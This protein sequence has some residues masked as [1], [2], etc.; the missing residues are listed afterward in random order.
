MTDLNRFLAEATASG[1]IPGVSLAALRAGTRSAEHYFGVRG[2]HDRAAADAATVFEA[3]SL[4]KPLV[5]SREHR[6]MLRFIRTPPP[7]LLP[8]PRPR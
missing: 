2:A 1:K 8:L 6:C 4:T 3:A 5:A 7:V